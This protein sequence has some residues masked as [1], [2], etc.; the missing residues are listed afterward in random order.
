V[1]FAR[2]I[3]LHNAGDYFAAHEAWESPWRA[4]KNAAT[5]LLLQGLI[6]VTAA[7][8][9]HFVMGK[10][11]SAQKLVARGLAKL[12]HAPDV[13]EGVDLKQFRSEAAHCE[14]RFASGTMDESAVPKFQFVDL[15][16]S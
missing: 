9:K 7:F 16:R 1:T 8:H 13:Y 5:R 15:E 6:Q 12:E 14:E 4:E 3:K 10:P 2:G 11:A